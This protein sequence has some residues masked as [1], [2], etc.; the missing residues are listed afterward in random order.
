MGIETAILMGLAAGNSAYNIIKGSNAKAEA[1]QAASAAA[2][3]LVM[4]ELDQYKSL[5]VPALG[6]EL[7][8]QNLQQRLSGGLQALQQGG[9]STVLGGLTALNQ[10]SAAENLQLASKAQEA[11]YA[12]DVAQAENA[13]EVERRNLARQAALEQQRLVGAQ[14]AAAYGQRQIES[15]MQGLVE[16]AGNA[17]AQNLANKPLYDTEN[18]YTSQLTNQQ[19]QQI[20]AN[21]QQAFAPQLASMNPNV[22]MTQIAPTRMG[23]YQTQYDDFLK[24]QGLRGAQGQFD[25]QYQWSPGLG[26][27]Q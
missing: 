5:K 17:L 1:N 18:Q 6:L 4:K 10:Q 11:Q 13:Q 15:G 24:L 12:R 20:G 27:A 19:T 22:A 26:W 9:A 23:G 25:A 3:S 16:T 7:A 8:Q 14:N 21:A 2:Q